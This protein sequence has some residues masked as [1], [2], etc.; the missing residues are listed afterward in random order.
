MFDNGVPKGAQF[1][2]GLAALGSSYLQGD[3]YG[4]GRDAYDQAGEW[5]SNRYEQRAQELADGALRLS[6]SP[7]TYSLEVDSD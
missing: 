5:E 6:Y 2:L 3:F 7:I 4:E 1:G